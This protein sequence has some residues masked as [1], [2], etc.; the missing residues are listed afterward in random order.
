MHLLILSICCSVAVSVLLKV[1]RQRGIPIGQAIGVNYGVASILCLMLLEPP[2]HT[3]AS[4]SASWLLLACL[5]L[6]LPGV[7]LIMAASVRHAGIVLS[8]A[9][10]RLSL[11]V[12]LTA[13]FL[14]FGEN[15]SE[16]KLAAISVA[17]IALLALLIRP[18]SASVQSMKT[19]ICLVGVW[20]GYGTIDILFKEMARQGNAFS[21]TLFGVFVLAGG[22]MLIGLTL[23]RTQWQ[24]TGVVGGLALG[25]LNFGNIYFYISAHQAYAANPSLVFASMNIGVI[26]LGTLTGAVLFKEKLSRINQ[27]GIVMAM[28]AIALLYPR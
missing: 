21:A 26:A 1:A 20:L 16:Q 9:A 7:F 17:F 10:Q 24:W 23:A 15:V 19:L 5:G 6:L 11:L 4:P 13:A 18:R 22:V 14:W 27:A 3:L 8:D 25:L 12:P 2:L 28:L